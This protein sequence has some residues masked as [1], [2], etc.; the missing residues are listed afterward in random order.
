MASSVSEPR[1]A[2]APLP[3]AA[4]PS[5]R[6]LAPPVV[7]ALVL[8]LGS[9]PI[10]NWI[11]GGHEYPGYGALVE[12]WLSGGAIVVGLGLVL[13]IASRRIPGLWRDDLTAPLAAGAAARPWRTALL[14]A[15]PALVLYA[16]LAQLVFDGRPLLIDEIVQ[17][18]HA[19]IFADGA[20]WRPVAAHPEFF[21]SMH[22]I[23]MDGKV[24]SQ[25]PAG[26]P[27]MLLLGVLAGAPWLV[28]PCFGAVSVVAFYAFVRVAEPRPGVALGAAALFAVA[29]FVAFMAGSYMN[30]V[31]VLTWLLVALAALA[32]VVTAPRPRPLA[33]LLVGLGFGLAATIR[34]LDALAFAL[35][36]GLWLLA[37]AL[38]DRSR[39]ADALPA[40]LGV[41]VP[42]LV[43]L[44]INA[45]T[46]GHPL[47][48]GYV[49]LWGTSHEIGFHEVPWGPPHTP[50]RGLELVSLNFLRLQSY[51]F[52]TPLPSLLPAIAALALARRLAPLDR[53][54]LVSAGLLAGAYFAYWHDGFYLGPRFMYPLAPVLVLWSARLPALVRER[55]GAGLG[56]RA[57][58]YGGLVALVFSAVWL[59][60]LRAYQYTNGM[61]TL[62]WDAGAAAEAAGIRNA[63]VL[64]RESWGAELIARLWERGVPRTDAERLYRHVDACL[65][66]ERLDQLEQSGVAG[67]AALAA[68]SP[69]Q[70]D[71]ARLVG[72][73][74]SPDT[75]EQ[76]L[77]GTRY[78]PRCVRRIQEDRLGFT[79][80]PPLLLAQTG[81]NVY[82]RDLHARDSLLLQAYPDRPIYLLK[83]AS[84]AIGE[85]PKFFP[86][87]VDS[88]WRAW[89]EER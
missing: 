83:P 51:L 60:P 22:V 73:P 30:H 14:L 15:A 55:F 66:H 63:L 36:A 74:F 82:A 47:R 78:T 45:Q 71:S 26:G 43:L 61:V 33:G 9:L 62:R 34:P 72:S 52:E 64:V 40:G 10:A 37:R 1:P 49:E 41:A 69:L 13:A 29:P 8:V 44:W 25:F 67:A 50:A 20:L 57:V 58:V 32:R 81:G 31:T 11:A 46:T 12:D 88:L 21:G 80:Y 56:H 68:L 19:R 75:T 87:A 48:F 7:A 18:F 42:V 53:Y 5:F 35:P 79:L 3:G 85:V 23:D 6:S 54:L 17:L 76:L 77:P 84:P 89:R 16:V 27:A 4:E 2:R 70:A 28:G 86:V 65:L 24:Y 38:R 59:A 39:W